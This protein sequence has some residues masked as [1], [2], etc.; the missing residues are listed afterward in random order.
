MINVL[1]QF[2]EDLLLQIRGLLGQETPDPQSPLFDSLYLFKDMMDFDRPENW[3]KD[4][5]QGQNRFVVVDL[6]VSSLEDVDA[7]ESLPGAVTRVDILKVMDQQGND[8]LGED[9]QP[10][11]PDQTSTLLGERNVYQYNSGTDS[12]EV[13]GTTPMNFEDHPRWAGWRR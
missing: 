6:I 5:T 12:L 3:W 8:I 10:V 13:I 7:L 4:V 2:R 9:E 11:Y 1:V